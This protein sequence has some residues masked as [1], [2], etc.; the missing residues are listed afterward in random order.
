VQFTLVNFATIARQISLE[1]IAVHRSLPRPHH[2]RTARTLAR[3]LALDVVLV[4]LLGVLFKAS[5]I[6][7]RLH[8][9]AG[10]ALLAL[11]GVHLVAHRKVITAH[12]KQALG[13]GPRS[14]GGAIRTVDLV[15]GTLLMVC[16]VAIVASGVPFA[17]ATIKGFEAPAGAQATHYWASAVALALTGAHVGIHL[18]LVARIARAHLG[19]GYH[20]ARR[21]A[22]ALAAVGVCALFTSDFLTWLLAPHA[23]ESTA[24]ATTLASSLV[25]GVECA[26]LL[27]LFALSTH[28]T[29]RCLTR[30][31]ATSA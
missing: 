8:M 25:T 24:A 4:L 13:R 15:L 27:A 10:L 23:F 19:A 7:L 26:G 29:K 17:I 22:F 5:L 11:V 1:R 16:L 3:N 21:F 20:T 18:P 6:T 2:A 12:V 14:A 30:R 31:A 9:L 28:F